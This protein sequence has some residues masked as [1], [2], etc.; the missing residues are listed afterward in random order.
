MPRTPINLQPEV[1]FD[2]KLGDMLIIRRITRRW[3][4]LSKDKRDEQDIN[5]DVTAVHCNGNPLK[6]RELLAADDFNFAHDLG[7]IAMHLDR[8]TGKL[9]HH[10]VPRFTLSTEGSAQ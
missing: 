10:F 2:T 3:Q 7:G 4:E 9:L 5:M 8:T 6:L 1:S